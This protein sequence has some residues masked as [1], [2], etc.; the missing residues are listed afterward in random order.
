[1]TSQ[2]SAPPDQLVELAATNLGVIENLRLVFGTGMTAITGETGAGKTL[3]LTAL[4][5]L[6]GSRAEAGMVGPHGDEAIVEGRFV[7][8]GAEVVL[9]R[10]VPRSG[11]SRAYVNGRLATASSLADHGVALV[12][13]HGQNGHTALATASAQRSALDAFGE[14]DVTEL[15]EA[16]AQLRE[17]RA[18]SETLGGDE[19]ERLRQLEL[20][21]YQAA[22]IESASISD[23]DEDERLK[24][25]EEGL[26]EA[27]AHQEAAAAVASLLEAEG[28]TAS[29]IDEALAGLGGR[30]ALASIARQ[31]VDLSTLV[32]EAATE[33]RGLVD[34]LEADP[35]RL[36][37]IQERRRQLSELR[38]KYGD[39]LAEV[40]SFGDEAA[41]RAEELEDHARL[42]AEIDQSIAG[43]QA[44]VDRLASEVGAARRAAA[45]G[46][47]ERVAAHLHQLA[48]PTASLEVDVGP[49]AGDDVEMLVSMN[50][51][52]APQP[53]AKIASGGELART[54]LAVRLVLSGQPPVMV[55]DEVDAGIGGAAAHSVGAAL[56]R[57]GR[58]SQVLVVTHLAQVAAF[59][60]QQ[61]A[62]VK[63]D[64]GKMVSVIATVLAADDRVV[65]LSRMLSG[66][67]DSSL[68]RETAAELLDAAGAE[69]SIGAKRSGG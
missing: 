58:E 17:L 21:R 46:L 2:G 35:Q 31:L 36:A 56:A 1:M 29:G 53:L 23:P 9:Q 34:Q 37:E 38:R 16:R 61:V 8:G 42:A 51:G 13:V 59:A 47:A 39:T 3:V 49:G 28:P 64:D 50:T 48:L 12:E 57:L 63:S 44:V 27:G 69:R 52:S 45:P 25:E 43:A 41:R 33:A 4:N 68:A 40:L 20:Y 14:V 22:E 55:F 5:L 11:R 15:R 32:A 30:D 60:D 19:R 7:F 10:I 67:P 18:R 62:V 24:A 26:G 66:T 6:I 54:M 65:E